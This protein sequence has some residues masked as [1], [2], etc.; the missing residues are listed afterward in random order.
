MKKILKIK[1]LSKSSTEHLL[2]KKNSL[3]KGLW[4]WLDR[5]TL[6]KINKKSAKE[7]IKIKKFIHSHL[8]LIKTSNKIQKPTLL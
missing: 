8:V 4:L 6:I 3:T 7:K 5:T 1:E 2:L